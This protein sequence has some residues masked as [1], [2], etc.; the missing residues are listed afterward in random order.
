MNAAKYGSNGNVVSLLLLRVFG[1]LRG[2]GAR[3][4]LGAAVVAA[5]VGGAIYLWQQHGETVGNDPRYRLKME[6]VRISQRPKWI[7]SDV[8]S[9]ALLL[10][11]LS[12][13][14]IREEDLTVR[15]AQ[16]FAMHPWVADVR[17]VSKDFPP[18]VAIDLT[19][20]RPV[21]MVQV[22]E[23]LLPVDGTG[24]L[25][26]PGDFASNDA[27]KYPRI[28]IDQS[29]PLGAEGTPWGDARV[30]GA[31]LIADLLREKWHTLSLHRIQLVGG[32]TQQAAGLEPVFEIAPREGTRVVWGHAPG[33]EA[34]GEPSASLKLARLMD[35]IKKNGLLTE[36]GGPAEIDLSNSTVQKEPARTARLGN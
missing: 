29:M 25:L 26:P 35:Y 19:Y 36:A 5:I 21:A 31:A 2:V 16:A 24:V 30:R 28:A 10:G 27:R 13:P 15:M 14:D 22:R 9:E 17:R 23:G 12:D 1:P 20:R 6:N 11:S 4:V 3:I 7:R 34:P 32:P 33:S 8:K 18:R